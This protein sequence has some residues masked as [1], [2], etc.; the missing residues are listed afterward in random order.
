M[1]IGLH[2]DDNMFTSTIPVELMSMRSLVVLS[3]GNNELSGPI[4]P[5]ISEL[6][7]LVELKLSGNVLEGSV[8]EE[9]C[10]LGLKQLQVDSNAQCSCCSQNK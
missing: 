3:L 7:D 5:E 6:H 2:L 8:P 9:V 1:M 10:A 4:P